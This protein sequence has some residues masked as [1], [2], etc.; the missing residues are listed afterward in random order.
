ML[1]RDQESLLASLRSP[2]IYK[3]LVLQKRIKSSTLTQFLY[4]RTAPYVALSASTFCCSSTTYA[5]EIP[6]CLSLSS[7]FWLFSK[8]FCI[9]VEPLTLSLPL[10]SCPARLTFSRLGQVLTKEAF[11]ALL[12]PGAGSTA[13]RSRSCSPSWHWQPMIVLRRS[14]RS[15]GKSVLPELSRGR[16]EGEEYLRYSAESFKWDSPNGRL[17]PIWSRGSYRALWSVLQR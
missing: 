3:L 15:Q 9:L 11:E 13:L 10:R 6:Q 2:I 4:R 14:H 8:S 7:S 12:K 1:Y 16:S 5:G 17:P